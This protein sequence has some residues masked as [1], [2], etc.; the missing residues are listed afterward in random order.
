MSWPEAGSYGL[1]HMSSDWIDRYWQGQQVWLDH[2]SLTIQKI[3]LAL[4][5]W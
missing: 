4:T 5:F 2:M 3:S 1:I